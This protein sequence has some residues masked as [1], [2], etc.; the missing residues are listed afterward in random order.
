M[1]PAALQ[2]LL[3]GLE[4]VVQQLSGLCRPDTF[5]VDVPPSTPQIVPVRPEDGD[6]GSREYLGRGRWR[7]RIVWP[8]AR[9]G[10][11]GPCVVGTGE[12]LV[13]R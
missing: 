9:A 7:G 4:E 5:G 12:G 3:T 8:A 10:R 13:H 2:R 11:D 6:A 1:D